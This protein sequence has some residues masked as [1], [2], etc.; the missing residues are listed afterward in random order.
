L[1]KKLGD[2]FLTVLTDVPPCLKFCYIEDKKC[3]ILS[4]LRKQESISSILFWIPACAGM[5]ALFSL[6]AGGQLAMT[7]LLDM[8]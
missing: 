5:T 6:F 3:H 2:Y 4:F 7:N 1:K 8:L